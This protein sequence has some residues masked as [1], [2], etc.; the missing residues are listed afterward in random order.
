MKLTHR[1]ALV[2]VPSQSN[3]A[4]GGVYTVGGMLSIERTVFNMGMLYR[5][6]VLSRYV[7]QRL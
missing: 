2:E 1:D 3:L 6:T 5:G 7:E 4:K